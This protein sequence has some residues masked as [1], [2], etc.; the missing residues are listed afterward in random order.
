[1]AGGPKEAAGYEIKVPWVFNGCVVVADRRAEDARFLRTVVVDPGDDEIICLLNA[2]F[3]FE[4]LHAMRDGMSAIKNMDVVVM[5]FV[6]GGPLGQAFRDRSFFVSVM[7]GNGRLR[8]VS[9]GLE[10]KVFKPQAMRRAW[11]YRV[12]WVADAIGMH[13]AVE[14]DAGKPV[15]MWFKYGFDLGRIR[16]I[17]RAFVVDDEVVAFGVIRVTQN[18]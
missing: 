7:D 15:A 16:N 2:L 3:L 13:A 5:L 1:M 4:D 6:D 11:R 14:I 17:R 8:T 10:A 18:R 12:V 9:A